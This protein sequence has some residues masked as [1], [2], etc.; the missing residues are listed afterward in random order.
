MASSQI[1]FAVFGEKRL[2]QQRW[3]LL[4][5]RPQRRQTKNSLDVLNV[6]RL[7]YGLYTNTTHRRTSA[8]RS[9]AAVIQDAGLP[10]T[11]HCLQ[12]LMS[13]RIQAETVFYS[14]FHRLNP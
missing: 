6:A 5:K 3:T 12:F 1:T 9:I 11:N 10:L 2:S 13:T 14:L 8:M 4:N 7:I